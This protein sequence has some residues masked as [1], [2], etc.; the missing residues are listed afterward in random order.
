MYESTEVIIR[1]SDIE[2]QQALTIWLD[3]DDEQAIRFIKEKIVDKTLR[4]TC[5]HPSA[6]IRKM[7]PCQLIRSNCT[8]CRSGG[9]GRGVL[10]HREG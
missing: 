2:V 5:K 1:L 10:L 4:T 9:I 7:T 8:C 6:S 3:N